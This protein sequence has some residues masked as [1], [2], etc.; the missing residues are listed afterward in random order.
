MNLQTQREIDGLKLQISGLNQQISGLKDCYDA[1]SAS[2]RL[3]FDQIN[4]FRSNEYEQVSRSSVSKFFY[5]VFRLNKEPVLMHFQ[6][7]RRWS[8]HG[9][10]V[11]TM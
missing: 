6:G 4:A 7:R 2:N 10:S 11:Q 3:L 9:H 5:R 1:S 8:G